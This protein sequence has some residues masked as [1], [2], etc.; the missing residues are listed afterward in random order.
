[1][2]GNKRIN[3][4]CLA[5]AYCN[6]E[7]IDGVKSVGFSLS[8]NISNIYSRGSSVPVA[9]YGQ[10]PEIEFTYS[11]HVTN[12]SGFPGFDNEPGLFDFVSFDMTIG[13]DTEEYLSTPIDTIRASYMLLSSVTYNLAIDGFFSIER[14]FKGWNKTSECGLGMGRQSASSGTI[15]TR[16]S[17]LESS[18]LPS[19]L[20]GTSIQNIKTTMTIN[21]AFVGEFATRKPY[22]SYITFPITTECE[23]ETLLTDKL[24]NFDFNTLQT[25][26]KN[27]PLY[28][29]N[30]TISTCTG[31]SIQIQKASLTSFSYSGGEADTNGSNLKLTL[32]YTGY[33][34][35]S[36]INPVIYI[37]DS[38]ND[39]CQC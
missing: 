24:D 35:P 29:Q 39:P 7:P 23:I 5:L 12:S 14:T 17:F 27:G 32:K 26:C 25:A 3:Y 16:K 8:R 4:A 21:R 11:S 34:S 31:N 19:I 36:G 18:S 22:A 28:S 33:Q 6:G 10:L 15:M 9:T 2:A 13:S 20:N 38:I 1:M 37:D 30:M